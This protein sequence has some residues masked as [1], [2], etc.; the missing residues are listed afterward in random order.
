[1]DEYT[2]KVLMNHA[3][4]SGKSNV[5]DGY[6]TPDEGYGDP[7]RMG[8]ERIAKMLL[9]KKRAKRKVAARGVASMRIVA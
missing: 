6:L 5:T 7:L 2:V 3:L 9:T 4:P 1:M 8:V